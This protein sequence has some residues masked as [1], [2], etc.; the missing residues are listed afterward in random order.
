[1]T[2]K[3]MKKIVYAEKYPETKTKWF[4][5]LECGHFGVKKMSGGRK[6]PLRS[7]CYDCENRKGKGKGERE[8]TVRSLYES[9]KNLVDLRYALSRNIQAHENEFPDLFSLTRSWL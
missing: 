4:V 7:H 5:I 9:H 1:M 2:D 8:S 6:A 3:K